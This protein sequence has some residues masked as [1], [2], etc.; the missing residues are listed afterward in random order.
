MIGGR[1]TKQ[2]RIGYLTVMEKDGLQFGIFALD[3]GTLENAFNMIAGGEAVYSVRNVQKVD[4][5]RMHT[6][7]SRWE[8]EKI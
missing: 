5:L 8:A 1:A 6:G 7:V 4:V 3:H 2:R